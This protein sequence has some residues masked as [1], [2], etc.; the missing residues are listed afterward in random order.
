[1]ALPEP[2]LAKIQQF[3]NRHSPAHLGDQLRLEF[4]ARAN[5]ITIADCRPLWQGSP[6][7][8]TCLPIAQLRYQPSNKRRTL[9]WAD[10]N[11]RWKQA[12]V[13]VAGMVQRKNTKTT[14]TSVEPRTHRAHTARVRRPARQNDAGVT[15]RSHTPSRAAGRS[16][17]RRALVPPSSLA[18]ARCAGGLLRA[19]E[20]R[21]PHHDRIE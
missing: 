15:A 21:G 2:A 3:C 14:G 5:S 12:F 1:M 11:D 17:R 4:T 13:D 9:Y 6:G 19:R 7:E 18:R 20:R 16:S 8:W 10:R